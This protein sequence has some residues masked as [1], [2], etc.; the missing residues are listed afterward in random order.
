MKIKS[1][2]Y[3]KFLCF[4]VSMFQLT[5]FANSRRFKI[6]NSQSFKVAKSKI[7]LSVDRYCSHI[8]DFK[9]LVNGSSGLCGPRL[10]QHFQYVRFPRFRY[11]PKSYFS[12]IIRILYWILWSNL[13][14]PELKIIGL[15]SHG[16][17]RQ[18]RKPC[19]WWVFWFPQNETEKLLVQTEAKEFY[20][21]RPRPGSRP[22]VPSGHGSWAGPSWP[23][24]K[25]R[26]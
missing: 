19:K 8:Q 22:G 18:V 15:G 12:E 13:V 5:Q 2:R 1:S 4:N 10:F 21:P 20:A 11:F 17:V 16:H 14:S 3:S 24:A 9:N 6:S 25:N 26:I 7:S 23:W